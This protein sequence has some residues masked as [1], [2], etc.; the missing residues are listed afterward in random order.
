MADLSETETSSELKIK[1]LEE[2]NKKR[3]KLTEQD[4]QDQ[5]NELLDFLENQDLTNPHQK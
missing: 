3:Q 2:E 4:I 1:E 5:K